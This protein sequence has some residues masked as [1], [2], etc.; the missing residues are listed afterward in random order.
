MSENERYKF[1]IQHL[2]HDIYVKADTWC[3]GN[4]WVFASSHNNC[5]L[6][7]LSYIWNGK[8]KANALNEREWGGKVL[9]CVLPLKY[10]FLVIP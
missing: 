7:M 9:F 2:F 8:V 1:E 6:K 3:I 5:L 10:E 4:D